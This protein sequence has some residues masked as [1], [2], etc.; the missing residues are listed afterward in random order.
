[1]LQDTHIKYGK[2]HTPTKE[3]YEENQEQNEQ[4]NPLLLN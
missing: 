1:M 2:L 3:Q 4:M